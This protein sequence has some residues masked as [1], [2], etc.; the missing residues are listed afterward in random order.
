MPLDAQRDPAAEVPFTISPCPHEHDHHD[1]T[2]EMVAVDGTPVTAT[3]DALQMLRLV[4]DRLGAAVAFIGHY[5]TGDMTAAEMYDGVEA[6]MGAIGRA[7]DRAE[8]VLR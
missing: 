7:L 3:E 5:R 1:G 2:A 6:E 4:Q 8:A